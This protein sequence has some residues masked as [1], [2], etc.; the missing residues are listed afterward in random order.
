DLKADVGRRLLTLCG[1]IALA[2]AAR[3][4]REEALAMLDRC[5]SL[6]DEE[7]LIE[8]WHL[9]RIEVFEALGDLDAIAAEQQQLYRRMGRSG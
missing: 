5:R 6:L 2:S 7:R 1:E 4:S 8:R 3:G 9:A